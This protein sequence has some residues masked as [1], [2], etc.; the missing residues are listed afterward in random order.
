NATNDD[1]ATVA[2]NIRTGVTMWV[3]R[4]NGPASGADQALSLAVR[5][6]RV[7]V[8]GGSFGITSEDDYATIA[9]NG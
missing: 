6:G 9:Y 2:Y 8:T 4:Y 1:Y 3:R 7:F 5:A